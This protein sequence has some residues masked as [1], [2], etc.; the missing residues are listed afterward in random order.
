MSLEERRELWIYRRII[1]RAQ[2]H[3]PSLC[4][5]R[6]PRRDASLTASLARRNEFCD[7]FPAIR[8]QHG[9]AG[10]DFPDVLAQTVLQFPKAHTLHGFQCSSM[11]LHCQ[12]RVLKAA[13]VAEGIAVF[14]QTARE[15]ERPQRYDPRFSGQQSSSGRH[16]GHDIKFDVVATR[17]RG[18]PSECSLSV[19]GK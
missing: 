1:R 7:H 10:P 12:D 14:A 4:E 16:G 19:K 18:N 6:Q 3:L 15:R 5:C 17:V 2:R 8:H 13:A 11:K 9:L